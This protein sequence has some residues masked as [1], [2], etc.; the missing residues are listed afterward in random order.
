MNASTKIIKDLLEAHRIT[1]KKG[2]PDT[3]M[4]AELRLSKIAKAVE[5]AEKWLAEPQTE[6]LAYVHP[7]CPRVAH[8]DE[9]RQM[10]TEDVAKWKSIGVPLSP[11][12]VIAALKLENTRLL[13][14]NRDSMD[15]FNMLRV[16]FNKTIDVCEEMQKTLLS[17]LECTHIRDIHLRSKLALDKY[18]L[19]K[20]A[21]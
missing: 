11:D 9:F 20:E 13:A 14:A 3:V 21:Q 15:N 18:Q 1:F 5:N 12:C 2:M 17:I 7:S 8:A 16:D 4:K 6:P 19:L 10:A